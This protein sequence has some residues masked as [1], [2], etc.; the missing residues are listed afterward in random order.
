[1][2]STFPSKETFP[3]GTS[4]DQ[5]KEEQRLRIKA[6]AISS[7]YK[8]SEA[9]GWVLTTVWNVIGEQ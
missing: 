6:G 7:N 5:I 9:D 8:G 2:P 4:E 1:M 3:A